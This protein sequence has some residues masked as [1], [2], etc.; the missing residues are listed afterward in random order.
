M[1]A[2]Y[3]V[4]AIEPYSKK[5][6]ESTPTLENDIAKGLK[7]PYK[8]LRSVGWF[9]TFEEANEA[10]VSNMCDIWEYSYDY[11]IIEETP[12]GYYR[13]APLSNTDVEKG[14]VIHWY[15]YNEST[16][17]Y[18]KL[19]KCPDSLVGNSMCIYY[20]TLG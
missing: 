15:K 17:Q 4:T 16:E 18:E 20:G 7:K 10:V 8:Y 3:I 14:T 6:F 1:K 2:I 19:D 5:D 9:P 11:A 13:S 12:P